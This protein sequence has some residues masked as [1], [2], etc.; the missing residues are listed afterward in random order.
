MLS[1]YMG[2]FMGHQEQKRVSFSA[3]R[4]IIYGSLSPVGIL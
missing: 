4:K 3:G 2:F 1:I